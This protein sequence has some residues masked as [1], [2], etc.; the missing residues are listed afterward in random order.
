M[1]SLTSSV[2]AL[3][4]KDERRVSFLDSAGDCKVSASELP[5]SIV[6]FFMTDLDSSTAEEIITPLRE[7]APIDDDSPIHV[8]YCYA[9]VKKP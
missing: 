5:T 7:Y 9:I 8:T 1:S 2:S 4:E 3:L 6:G